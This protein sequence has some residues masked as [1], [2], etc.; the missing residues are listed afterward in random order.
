MVVTGVLYWWD[1][2]RRKHD[3][4]VGLERIHG[5][6]DGDVLILAV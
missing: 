5:F 3:E 1:E 2:R 6:G 4:V